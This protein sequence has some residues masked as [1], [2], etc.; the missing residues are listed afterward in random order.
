MPNLDLSVPL[1]VAYNF[2]GHGITG[3]FSRGGNVTIGV[4]ATYAQIWKA[5]VSFTHYMATDNDGLP[6]Q[7]VGRDFVAFNISR[8]F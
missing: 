7:N 4:N 6:N 5:G 2:A 3:N 8:T 1:S